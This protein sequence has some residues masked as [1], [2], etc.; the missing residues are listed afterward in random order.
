MNNRRNL[1]AFILIVCV[2]LFITTG[3]GVYERSTVD[4][5]TFLQK[6]KVKVEYSTIPA[7]D[8]EPLGMDVSNLAQYSSIFESEQESIK[9]S[10][11]T[12]ASGDT[13]WKIAQNAYGDG[14]MYPY[15]MEINNMKSDTILLGQ[16]I[17]IEY[18]DSDEEYKNKL[19]ECYSKIKEWTKPVPTMTSASGVKNGSTPSNMSYVGKFFVTGYD[20]WCAHCCGGDTSGV[21]ASGKVATLG[22]TVATSKQFAMGTKLY[23]E[24][25]GTY[26]VEDRGCAKG[27]IDIATD[28]HE[29]CGLLTRDG[30]NVYIVN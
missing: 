22:R 18:F 8:V 30:I 14:C 29:A 15:L 6:A 1:I 16:V 3:C 20:A 27:I 24:G 19:K 21:T 7:S 17:K 2:S 13:L 9:P 28:S 12:V 11:W 26:V 5:P 4:E 10:N 25:Y 23:V